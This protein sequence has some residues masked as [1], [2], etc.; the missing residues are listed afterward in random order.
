MKMDIL[1]A[2]KLLVIPAV[3]GKGTN[4][5]AFVGCGGKTTF[6]NSL[7]HEYKHLKVLVTPTT[8][9]MP[10]NEEGVLLR[11]TLQECV[12]HI[13]VT[14]IQCLGILN[15][16]TGKLEALP[17]ELLEEIHMQYDLILLEADGSRGLPC[18][19]WLPGEPVI[20]KFV[21][22][23][24]GIVTMSAI[25]MPADEEHVLRLPEFLA[26]TGLDAGNAITPEALLTMVCAPGGMFKNSIG[27]MHLFI[28]RAEDEK[29]AQ[30]SEAW[31]NAVYNKYP[32]R[33]ATLAYG[34]AQ[35]NKW[36][37]V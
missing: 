15:R 17:G 27:K 8:K 35:T 28:N 36:R 16:T 34:S 10:M 24:V 7:A 1:S 30:L 22:H 23:S 21:T 33:F 20:P 31:L 12:N 9:I 32:K 3:P 18:K 6:I 26:L 13:P 2:G 5:L 19:G 11:K 4:I 14:G 37:K 29:T 25:G